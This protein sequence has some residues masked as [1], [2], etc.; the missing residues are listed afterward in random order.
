MTTHRTYADAHATLPPDSTCS[1][2]LGN[3]GEGGYA[4][5]WNAP[6][7]QAFRISNGPWNALK[8]FTWTVELIAA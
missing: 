4:E 2:Y 5:R 3:P 1:A 7:G 6:N 8:P